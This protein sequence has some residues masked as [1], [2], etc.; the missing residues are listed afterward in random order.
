MRNKAWLLALVLLSGVLYAGDVASFANLGFSADGRYFMFAQYGIQEES[1]FPYVELFVVDV[2]ANDFVDGGVKR[3]TY[4][5]PAEPGFI[6]EGALFA[7]IGENAALRDEYGIDHLETGR[8]LYLL[9]DGEEPKENLD[10]RDFV[11][12]I[13]YKVTLQQNVYGSGENTR[14][15]FYIDL[16]VITKNGTSEYYRVG[17]PNYQRRGVKS[18]RIKQVLLSPDGKS[19]VFLMEREEV[20][21][22]GSNIRYM[23]E[24]VVID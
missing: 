17:L 13:R 14:S 4:S 7:I 15:S 22:A 5:K 3:E 2:R 10:F 21:K 23:V 24:T 8:I 18:Y 1:S 11:S 6:G 19:L 12:G 16:T 9:V 20:D